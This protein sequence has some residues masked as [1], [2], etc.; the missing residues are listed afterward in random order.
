MFST[1]NYTMYQS[2]DE[3]YYR[4]ERFIAYIDQKM[5]D[6]KITLFEAVKMEITASRQGDFDITATTQDQIKRIAED[7]FWS[8]GFPFPK[9]ENYSS[10]FAERCRCYQEDFVV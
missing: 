8:I 10:W 6:T 7:Y 3:Q 1:N 2:E 5:Y 9:I 4:F